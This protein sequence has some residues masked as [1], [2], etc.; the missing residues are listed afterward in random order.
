VLA[1]A[2]E[3]FVAVGIAVPERE[4]DQL[5]D[6][7]APT[8]RIV[9]A[10]LPT[11]TEGHQTTLERV[12][13]YALLGMSGFGMLSSLGLGPL[14]I[15]LGMAVAQRL[16]NTQDDRSKTR[17]RRGQLREFVGAALAE[18]RLTVRAPLRE[19]LDEVLSALQE[20]F[21]AGIRR[22]R[23]EL[24]ERHEAAKADFRS[25]GKDQG[26]AT[27]RINQ[28]RKIQGELEAL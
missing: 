21:T 5:A 16:L 2:R 24:A 6:G 4:E 27:T 26:L 17:E 7:D 14:G 9:D 10:P 20:D 15:P 12:R 19:R 22:R 13:M 25:A 23:A 8:S 1:L 11:G 3:A 18:A 28:L